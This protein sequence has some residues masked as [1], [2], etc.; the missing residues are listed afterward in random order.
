MKTSN[1]ILFILIVGIIV[2]FTKLNKWLNIK[3]IYLVGIG[4]LF[5]LLKFWEIHSENKKRA[6]Y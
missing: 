3:P 5:F 4:F 6:L 1:T 2:Y